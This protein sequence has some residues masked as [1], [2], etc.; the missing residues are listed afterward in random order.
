MYEVTNYLDVHQGGDLAIIN[1]GGKDATD[2]VNGPQHPST[3]PT[4]LERFQI[5]HI[6]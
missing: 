6:A 3:V 4:L 2:A 5:G 1:W